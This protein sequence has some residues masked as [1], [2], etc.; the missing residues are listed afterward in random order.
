MIGSAGWASSAARPGVLTLRGR[1]WEAR[2]R[3]DLGSVTGA[4]DGFFYML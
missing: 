2:S 3:R 4:A 1:L